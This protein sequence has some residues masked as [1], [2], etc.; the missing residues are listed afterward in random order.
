MSRFV[1]KGHALARATHILA[2]SAACAV[3]A[4]AAAAEEVTLY[5]TRE[6][7]LIQPLLQSF[8]EQSGVK[9]NTVFVKDGL[10][11]RVKSEGERSPAEYKN[12]KES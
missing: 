11:E 12:I 4:V 5:T 6:P 8:T 2:L 9:V 1:F 3:P 7:G 10:L